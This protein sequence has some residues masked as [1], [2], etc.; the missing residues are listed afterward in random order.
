MTDGKQRGIGAKGEPA[1]KRS[2][3]TKVNR[4]N[5]RLMRK[6]RILIVEDEAIVVDELRASL[7]G[8]GYEVP[9]VAFCGEE[10]VSLVDKVQPDL[11]LMNIGLPGKLDGIEAAQRIRERRDIPIVYFTAYMDEER[12]ERA[13]STAPFAYIMKPYDESELVSVIETM[14]HK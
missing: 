14:L 12:L 10:A 9:A 2:P 1:M 4:G 11:V 7:Q 3:Q 6:P 5:G 13:K 8:R